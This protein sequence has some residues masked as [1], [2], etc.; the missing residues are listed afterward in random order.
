MERID[1]EGA[2]L[3]AIL[4]GNTDSA[5]VAMLHGL[6]TGNMAT[7]YSAF[8][9]PLSA[10]KNV[11]LYD[12]R[13]HG[14]STMPDDGFDLDTQ[15]RDLDAVLTHFDY[16]TTPVDLVGYSM[17]ALIALHFALQ[18]PQ[19]VGRL[20]LADAPMPACTHVAPSLDALA[21]RQDWKEAPGRR[22]E[23]QRQRLQHLTTQTTL[24]R[25]ISTMQAEP[26]EALAN[27]DKPVLLIYGKS[28]PCRSAGEHL[29]SVLPRAEL[30]LLDAGHDLPQDVPQPLLDHIGCFLAA[31]VC[32]SQENPPPA[33]EIS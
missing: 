7:W 28:S 29:R 25:D 19:R 6:I 14:T 26:D 23:R 2:T 21:A 11:L 10:N 8:A 13:G 27:F 1:V 4:L 33:Q 9:L 3:S 24:L 30:V 12:Q 22:G 17:G 18:H 31:P 16:G 20:V 15:A 32:N 5:P